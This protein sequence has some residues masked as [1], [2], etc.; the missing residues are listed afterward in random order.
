MYI[1]FYDYLLH[2]STG[3]TLKISEIDI[4]RIADEDFVQ[5]LK[6]RPK[7]LDW[8]PYIYKSIMEEAKIG[9]DK[10]LL[11]LIGV[12]PHAALLRLS[13]YKCSERKDCLSSQPKCTLIPLRKYK[14]REFPSCWLYES[15]DQKSSE[16]ITSIIFKWLDN[17]RVIVVIPDPEP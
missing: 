3:E 16:L 14:S 15:G 17:E 2:V 4:G 11:D 7:P 8:V 10:K 13:S 12:P 9:Y 6:D 1:E 5:I